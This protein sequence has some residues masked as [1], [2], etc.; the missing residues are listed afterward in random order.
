MYSISIWQNLQDIYQMGEVQ[1]HVLAARVPVRL[2]VRTQSGVFT[3]VGD[4]RRVL[5]DSK[6]HGG[7][8]PITGWTQLSGEE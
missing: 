5:F 8:S 2:G 6:Y 4:W 1:R 7:A 3:Y